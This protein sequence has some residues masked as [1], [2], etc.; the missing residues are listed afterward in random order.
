M[1]CHDHGPVHFLIGRLG[2]K[3]WLFVHFGPGQPLQDFTQQPLIPPYLPTYA[4]V[5]ETKGAFGPNKCTYPRCTLGTQQLLIPI[6]L[7]AKPLKL[8]VI[9]VLNPP[10]DTPAMSI[11]EVKLL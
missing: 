5:R 10:F 6:P 9:G 11:E 7:L 4:R 8:L 1:V 2:I 3:P